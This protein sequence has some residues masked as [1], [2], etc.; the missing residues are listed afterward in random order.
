[1]SKK[2]KGGSMGSDAPD[3]GKGL[4]GYRKSA[5]NQII[6]DRD[7]MLRQAEGRVRAAEARVAELEGELAAIRDRHSRMEE[8]LERLSAQVEGRS[9]ERTEPVPEGTAEERPQQAEAGESGADPDT[10]N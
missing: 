9:P 10:G 7:I 8:Q 3:L 1:M 6:A 2:R 4:F 5:V